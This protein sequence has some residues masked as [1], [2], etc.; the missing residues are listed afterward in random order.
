[1]SFPG[2]A[3]PLT[4]VRNYRSASRDRSAMGS[5]WR[6]N[7]DVRLQVFDE[8]TIPPWLS[9]W[10]AGLPGLPTAIGVHWG[11]SSSE[12]FLLDIGTR[13]YLPQAGSVATVAKAVA[14]WV[15][16]FP[17]GRLLEFD[18]LGCLVA[19][20]D[21]FGNLF[22]LKWEPTPLGLLFDHFC[23][24]AELAARN[25]TL[26]A[27]RNALLAWLCGAGPRPAADPAMWRVTSADFPL[28]TGPAGLLAQLEYA[29]DNLLYLASLAWPAESLDGGARRR[30]TRVT[31]PIGRQLTFSYYSAAAY[32]AT[33]G[34]D[35]FADDA[36]AGLLER[37]DGPAGASVAFRYER[38][39]KYPAELNESFLTAV[40][41][42]D[43]VPPG[44][45]GLVG[46]PAR[47]TTY[48]YQWPTPKHPSYQRFEAKL[49]R[50]YRD[51]Y[52][53]FVGCRFDAAYVCAG[54]AQHVPQWAPG[55]PRLLARLARNA[56]ISDVADNILTVTYAGEIDLETRYPADPADPAFDHAVAQRYGSRSAVQDPHTVAQD[57]PG[58]AWQTTMPK[59]TFAYCSAGPL[60]D[61]RDRSDAFLPSEIRKRYPLEPSP[62]P[63]DTQIAAARSRA[64]GCDYETMATL[65]RQLPGYRDFLPYFDQPDAPPSRPARLWR[66]PLA[67]EQLAGAQ[68]WDPTHNDLLSG[69]TDNPA[70]PTQPYIERI[71]GRRRE[72]SKNNN[73]ICSWVKRTDRDGDVVYFGLNYRGLPLVEAV[74]EKPNSFVY[75]DRFYNADGNLTEERRPT[76]STATWR[77][78]DGRTRWFYDD[79]DPTGNRGWNGW[80]PVFWAR[81]HNVIRVLV[82]SAGDAIDV[83]ETGIFTV[84]AGRFV[85]YHYEPL[86]NQVAS[87][88]SGSIAPGAPFAGGQ[89]P[90]TVT[91]HSIV[92]NVFDYQ[93]LSTA[94]PDADPRSIGP[95]LDSLR[96]WG[97]DWLRTDP[98][99][100]GFQLPLPLVGVDLNRDGEQGNRFATTAAARA[101]G[102]PVACL[103]WRPHGVPPRVWLFR[104]AP[105][106]LPAR[107]DGPDGDVTWHEYYL[108]AA[109]DPDS[110]L[111]NGGPPGP[112]HAQSGYAGFPGRTTRQVTG[113]T[114]DRSAQTPQPHIALAGPYAYLGIDAATTAAGLP[115][116]LATLG[117]PPEQ[118]DD[119]L[120]TL[121][122]DEAGAR[123]SYGVGYNRAGHP[124]V[125]FLPTGTVLTTTD[126]DGRITRTVDPRGTAVEATYDLRGRPTR[127]ATVSAGGDH[128]AE[129]VAVFDEADQ[130]ITRVDALT[131]GGAN[132]PSQPG[133]GVAWRYDYTPEGQLAQIIDPEGLTTQ[134]D[135]D[136]F[137]RRKRATRQRDP[138]QTRVAVFGYD[139]E[140]RLIKVE[141]SGELAGGPIMRQTAAYDGLDRLTSYFDERGYAWQL[142]WSDRDLLTSQRRS[143]EPFGQLP[144]S[145]PSFER[146]F[147]Y[148]DFGELLEQRDNGVL[149]LAA[150]RSRGGTVIASRAAGI[151]TTLET[152][153]LLGRPVWSRTPDGTNTVVTRREQPHRT[154]TTTIRYDDQGAP[155]TSATLAEQDPLGATAAETLI[156][157]GVRIRTAVGLDGLGRVATVTDPTGEQS[158][159]TRNMLGW[160]TTEERLADL[161]QGTAEQTRFVHDG[162]GDITRI[163]DA[164]S[165][166]VDITYNQFAEVTG[167]RINGT[168][169]VTTSC[170]YDV[171]GRV[172]DIT[173]G[174]TQLSCRYDARHDPVLDITAAGVD[175]IRRSFDDLGRLT[176]IEHTNP[177]LGWLPEDERTVTAALE[178]DALGR[179]RLDRTELDHRIADVGHLWTASPAGWRCFTNPTIG[180]WSPRWERVFD[181]AGRLA[182]QGPIA[183]PAAQT[184]FHWIGDIYVGR[185]QPQ[186]GWR[187]RFTEQ[188]E[189]DACLLPRR[190]SYR[191][192][193]T[194]AAGTPASVADAVKYAPSGWNAATC[195]RPLL[196]LTITRD[197]IGRTA[198]ETWTHGHPVTA[199]GAPQPPAQAHLRA[200]AYTLRGHLAR[201]WEDDA[202]TGIVPNPQSYLDPASAIAMVTTNATEWTYQ[203]EPRTDDLTLISEPAGG[204][205]FELTAP[206][207]PAHQLKRV[208]VDGYVANL[209]YDSAGR[210][211]DDGT[212]Q[213]TWHPDGQL[214][215]VRRAGALVEACAYD[216]L[217]RLAATYDRTAAGRPPH[218]RFVYDGDRPVAAVDDNGPRWTA[219][220]GPLI[221]QVIEYDPGSGPQVPLLDA[222]CSPLAVW[223]I[224]AGTVSTL[225]QY[226]P[227]GR[228]TVSDSAGV[229]TCAERGSALCSNGLPFAFT[230][231]LRSDATGL[232]W[233]RS[234]WYDPTLGQ[235]LSMDPAGFAGGTNRYLYAGGDPI[236]ATDPFG[237][238][239]HNTAK[240]QG[241]KKTDRLTIKRP[242]KPKL[243][244]D[245]KPTPGAQLGQVIPDQNKPPQA[246]GLPPTRPADPSHLAD[247]LAAVFQA[248][249][250]GAI[251]GVGDPT[252][253][254][255]LIHAITENTDAFNPGFDILTSNKVISV[256]TI[257]AETKNVAKKVQEHAIDLVRKTESQYQN[258]QKELSVVLP[259][260]S[261]R[262]QIETAEKALRRSRI[263]KG[264]P[265][266]VGTGLHGIPGKLIKVLAPIG[267]VTSAIDFGDDLARGDV[268]SAV[269]SGTAAVAGGLETVAL[270]AP[271]LEV[272]LTALPPVA[273]VV[274]T[275][276]MSW[277]LGSCLAPY[278]DHVLGEPGTGTVGEWYHSTF[279]QVK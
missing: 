227:D 24:A 34:P 279:Q 159:L 5:N 125:T 196:D 236:N 149:T 124:N 226:T 30:L 56:Y 13:L 154:I 57:A 100:F 49:E 98:Q 74:E 66:T 97:F 267:F 93:E 133:A 166:Q 217:G 278:V 262:K 73:R 129:T 276:S 271:V 199:A 253:R 210:V 107:V 134:L 191:A 20:T 138:G 87:T 193:E 40:T 240:P 179:V 186:P 23:S 268:T 123:T 152:V 143:D 216:G 165:Q 102:L 232:I 63:P 94:V 163:T 207:S 259:T 59:A 132:V 113:R 221:N 200:A 9:P 62:P 204:R 48:G 31:D 135:Y 273:G 269:S 90:A 2:P 128:L 84:A 223:D 233:M 114:P 218:A 260:G 18:A 78:R 145:A 175:L 92:G 203:R 32:T 144:G 155:R 116:A 213:Y 173:D 150:E 122:A 153:D 35:A 68:L 61:G 3:R 25:E 277:A 172:V 148:D 26:A 55:D 222:R 254:G 17:D 115:A 88:V 131:P 77:A 130:I 121:P 219:N 157:A 244:P 112:A 118:I 47:T 108:L 81:W 245:R 137:K 16:R 4:F 209:S 111:G 212:S 255:K 101:V 177:G 238:D 42:T 83:D 80:L 105:H 162:R 247:R 188:V 106:G 164:A 263:A 239:P 45:V 76:R 272:S 70:K 237:T 231:S 14:G 261:S 95:L 8:Q 89:L 187:S 38:P 246:P 60:R 7:W 11:D 37:V 33:P 53:T 15:M 160:V 86:F 109:N 119:L 141:Q 10:C 36:A 220:W 174:P 205:R 104:W 12:L 224:M 127:S 99:A 251:W 215:T 161:S 46:T 257:G 266:K 54:A 43:T 171:L 65:E 69:Q 234:R 185:T 82:E 156:G 22:A 29:R 136:P 241:A 182:S 252:L 139:I 167:T 275:F 211:T 256:K 214:A 1:M 176:R 120:A 6:H 58:D 190:V 27:R 51:Y 39:D 19:D 264:I 91:V 206:R 270:I 50:S 142:A 249:L 158:R 170:S 180:A 274:G 168:P 242:R 110:A 140:G 28:P 96:P 183:Q 178:Y 151:G 117:L 71:V 21:R 235:F 194:D 201:W 64:G 195:T 75:V 184:A 250:E 192:I 103:Q 225:S 52:A 146:T 208:T 72:T 230:G 85:D 248:I 189:L 41:R 258:L 202:L 79:F 169:A 67:A 147:G 229:E 198:I 197:Q 228:L 265:V 243:K 126:I 181:P 44:A